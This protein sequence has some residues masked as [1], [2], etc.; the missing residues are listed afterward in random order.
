MPGCALYDFGDMVRTTT[1]T[2][3]ED[4]RDLSKVRMQMPMFKKLCEGY[5]STAGNFLTKSEKSY[6]AF[7]GKLIT[8]TIGLRFLTDHLAGDTYFRIH[9]PGHNLD[10]ARTQFKLVESIEEMEE[11]M[12]KF[13][14]SCSS[15]A[16]APKKKPARARK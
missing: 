8:F 15:G 6:I 5:L 12:Q 9:R 13:A 7:A 11:A 16:V 4:E 1:S 2:T 3:L 10:R 14:D